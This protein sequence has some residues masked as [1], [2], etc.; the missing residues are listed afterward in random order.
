M[1]NHPFKLLL[2]DDDLVILRLLEDI[3]NYDFSNVLRIRAT[4]DPKEAQRYLESELI[5][6]FITDLEM[7]NING[8]ELLR[9]AKRKNV[10]T[11]VLFVTGHSNCSVLME[12]MEYGANDY[13]LKPVDFG[14]LKEAIHGM[15]Q[16][17]RRWRKALAGTIAAC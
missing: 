15:I 14:E 4:S 10:W 8:L 1:E 6:I 9:H 16:R 17:A 2:V 3:I 13:L 5:D 11:Q 12:A 7:P